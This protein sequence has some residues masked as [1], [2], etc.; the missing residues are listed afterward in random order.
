M[1]SWLAFT[2]VAFFIADWIL[3]VPERAP[4]EAGQF[5]LKH[6]TVEDRIFVWGHQAKI[7]LDARR[8]P[9]SRYILT[10]PLTGYIF[11]DPPPGVDTR[12]RIMPGA[13]A[14]LE[15]DFGKH[16]PTYIVDVQ[17]GRNSRYP[18]QDFPVL[19]RLLAERYL[20]VTRTREGVIYRLR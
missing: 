6:S 18:A 2:V 17:S 16:P 10:F 12:N 20:P 4:S 1:F 14:T 13:W 19:A 3:L 8:Q 5:L 9:A 15:E 11:G 7:Y